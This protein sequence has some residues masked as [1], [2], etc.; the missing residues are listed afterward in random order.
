MPER[1]KK[2]KKTQTPSLVLRVQACGPDNLTTGS[3]FKHV[4]QVIPI[5]RTRTFIL[6]QGRFETNKNKQTNK[7]PKKQAKAKCQFLGLCALT[8]SGRHGLT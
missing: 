2:K 8:N 4:I 7:K 1:K 3:A 6:Q 5:H